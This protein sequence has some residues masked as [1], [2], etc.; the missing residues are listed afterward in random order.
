[1]IR[2]GVIGIGN[3]GSNHCENIFSGKVPGMELACVC[4]VNPERIRWAKGKFGE[5][6]KYFDN[7]KELFASSDLMDLLIIATPHY[8][9]PE[10]A[11]EGFKNNLHVLTEKPAGVYTKQVRQMNEAADKSGKRF[12]IMYNQRTNCVYRKIRDLV[13]S[14][15]LGELK[16]MVW[17][18]TNWY[19]PQSYHD[20]SAW[21]STWEGEG[22]GVLLNQDPHQL[23]LWQWIV[24][25]PKRIRAFASFGKYYN[26]EVEDDVTAYA[27]YENGM[28]AT[29]ITS[30]GEAPGT[31]RLEISGTMGK[32]VTEQDT[33][34]FYRN[35]VDERTFNKTFQ[36]GFGFPEVWECNVP[37]DGGNKQHIGILENIV[38]VLEKGEEPIADGRE[39]IL[40]LSISNAIHLSAWTDKWVEPGSIDEDLFYNILQD[41]IKNSTFKK[42]VTEQKTYDG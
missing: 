15:E 6:V 28:T 7:S 21:R 30:T 36:R 5:S 25:M 42:N 8:D 20:S 16:R 41:K 10:L 23:D 34:K 24:G 27:E 32:I 1:M 22:G 3:M 11:I 12:F 18:I 37:T 39:G 14:G 40:G 31:N 17:I 13:K 19:R 35:R 4:D 33:I 38:N 2:A 26:I 29:F 9:H